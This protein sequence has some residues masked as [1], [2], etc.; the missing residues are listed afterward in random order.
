MI[1]K[2]IEEEYKE[3]E[4]FKTRVAGLKERLVKCKVDF[5][6]SVEEHHK[7]L[8]EA[9]NLY[10]ESLWSKIKSFLSGK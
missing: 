7:R 8:E 2:G 6:K 5:D 4:A 10:K 9:N 1:S 3:H